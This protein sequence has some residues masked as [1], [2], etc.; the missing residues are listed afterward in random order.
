MPLKDLRQQIA[1]VSQDPV[2]FDD[3][4]IENIRLGRQMLPT[5]K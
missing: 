5:R 4:V 3:T 2:L 1:I